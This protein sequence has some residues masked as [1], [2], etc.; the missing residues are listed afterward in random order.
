MDWLT[1]AGNLI[2]RIPLERVLIPR[3]DN[4]KALKDFA[5][6]VTA[7]VAQNRAPSEQKPM[8]TTQPPPRIVP[9]EAP[10]VHLAEPQPG[11]PSAEETVAYQSR[12]IGK[13]LLRMERHYAQK[14]RVGGVPC[15]CGAQK[16]LLDLESLCEETIPMV[17]SPQ[18]YYHVIEWIKK[19]GPK[20]TDEAA[21]SGLHDEEYPNFSHQARDFRK[22]VIGSLEP[23]ALF[24]QKPG[25]PE[26]TQ[27]LPVVSEE[28][29]ELIR[30]KAHQK[31]EEALSQ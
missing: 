4:T 28:E 14:M 19:V 25:E 7:P 22:D 12:E 26:G 10:K 8:V 1:F 5:A 21:K 11:G 31:I 3:P 24:P 9:Q 23:H 13:L 6:S 20:S 15:D 16:H 30:E 2:R 17:D 29:R 27:I 18:V